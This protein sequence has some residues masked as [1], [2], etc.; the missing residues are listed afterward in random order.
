MGLYR[1]LRARSK[2]I[3]HL[4]AERGYNPNSCI[5]ALQLRRVASPGGAIDHRGTPVAIPEGIVQTTK[6]LSRPAR[7]RSAL[8]LLIEHFN[9][10][11]LALVFRRCQD[12]VAENRSRRQVIVRPRL[13]SDTQLCFAGKGHRQGSPWLPPTRLSHAFYEKSR[14]II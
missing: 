2:D 8:A 3:W 5:Y 10:R 9:P 11:G 4:L 6:F 13:G 14:R 1:T 7:Y 12:K